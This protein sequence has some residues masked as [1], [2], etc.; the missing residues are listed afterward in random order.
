M[1]A[2][3]YHDPRD[4]KTEEV[5]MPEINDNEILVKVKACGIC[6]TDL[7]MY[8]IGLFLIWITLKSIFT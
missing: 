7:H 5:E 3:I 4:I 6:G 8:K 1:K 2:A